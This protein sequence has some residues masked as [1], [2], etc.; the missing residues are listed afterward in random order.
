MTNEC[1]A[2][3]PLAPP[4]DY[5]SDEDFK[6]SISEGWQL[7]ADDQEQVAILRLD[8][9]GWLRYL[10]LNEPRFDCDQAAAAHV[11]AVA[12]TEFGRM[13][14]LAMWLEGQSVGQSVSRPPPAS[15]LQERHIASLRRR[16]AAS[17]D[18]GPTGQYRGQQPFDLEQIAFVAEC[19]LRGVLNTIDTSLPGS[20]TWEERVKHAES[21]NRGP[22]KLLPY[23]RGAL[24]AA[25]EVLHILYAQLTNDGRGCCGPLDETKRFVEAVEQMMHDAWK[26]RGVTLAAPTARKIR[27]TYRPEEILLHYPDSRQHALVFAAAVMGELGK[28][29]R[30]SWQA[31]ATDAA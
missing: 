4:L 30:A 29:P 17:K 23:E 5:W 7:A 21:N 11:A 13:H 26:D 8:D 2:A 16:M 25:V 28:C 19:V 3:V 24:E 27:A 9:P 14:R 12:G 6:G 1:P 15:L 22:L 31:V 20:I 10:K 18:D